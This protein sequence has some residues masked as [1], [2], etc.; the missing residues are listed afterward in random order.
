MLSNNRIGKPYLVVL[1]VS[2]GVVCS[3][4]VPPAQTF[5]LTDAAGLEPHHVKVEAMEYQGRKAVRVTTASRDDESGFALLPGTDFQDG[6]IEADLAVKITTPPGVRMPGFAGVSFR[7]KADGSEYELFYLRPKNALSDDQAMRNHAVQ[8][9]AEPGFSWYKLRR[10]WPFVYES[11]AEIQ[12]E[13]WTKLRIEVSGR[14]AR[15]FLNGSAKPSLVVDGLKGANLRGAIGLWGYA[16]EESYFSNVR[17]TPKAALPLKNGS[18]ATGAWDVKYAS[19]AGRFEGT[20]KLTREG[21]KLS[22]TWSGGLGDGKPITGTWRDGYVELTFVAD[23][24]KGGDGAPGPNAAAM[25]GWI[26]GD[27]AKGRMRVEGRA[28]GMWMAQWKAE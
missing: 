25:E 24:P 20:M 9:S 4:Q 5:A 1:V 13:T 19:D 26:D 21:N 15:I 6:V 7:S 27:A 2:L 16:G 10:E 3:A 11:Y 18:D 14:S 23:W 17:I 28:L 22:G 8:Y 12:P